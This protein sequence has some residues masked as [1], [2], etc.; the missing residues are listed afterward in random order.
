VLYLILSLA[1]IDVVVANSCKTWT[2]YDPNEYRERL[3][4]CRQQAWDMVLI[5]GSPVAEGLDPGQLAGV[6]WQDASLHR[7][8]NLGLAGATTSAMWHAVEHGIV[9]PPRLL[10]YGITATDLNDGRDEPNGVW[11]LMDVGDV[12]EWLYRRPDQAEWCV[13]HFLTEH[14][15]RLWCL[16]YYRNAIRLWAADLAETWRPGSCPGAAA[17]ARYGLRF[18]AALQRDNGFAPREEHHDLTLAQLKVHHAVDDRFHF[19]ENYRLGGHL[20]YLH[21]ILDW[22]AERGVAVVLVD[23]PFAADLDAMHAPALA[24]YRAAL[25]DVECHRGVRVLRATR[26]A[27]GLDDTLFADRIHLNARG[28]ERLGTWV[29]G[30]L[31]D[32][33]A[34]SREGPHERH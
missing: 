20:Q 28:R 13:R 14:L 5:G 12:A 3:Q 1:A 22:A 17:D 15:A 27:V 29:R 2:A 9:F 30:H 8:F 33:G 34:T 24:V 23:M 16:Y 21:R 18:S 19:L 25:A 26:E 32:L 10:L 7:I 4:R 31:N 6:H 11:T